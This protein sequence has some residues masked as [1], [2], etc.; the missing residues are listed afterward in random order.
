M[1]KKTSRKL[2]GSVKPEKPVEQLKQVVPQKPY[3]VDAS[4]WNTLSDEQ[5]IEL[6]QKQ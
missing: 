4:L 1:S 5:K 3:W 6:C 2:G